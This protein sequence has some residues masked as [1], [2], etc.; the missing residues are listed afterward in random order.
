[1]KGQV[2]SQEEAEGAQQRKRLLPQPPGTWSVRSPL[3]GELKASLQALNSVFKV[4]P[5]LWV[6]A[7]FSTNTCFLIPMPL[8]REASRTCILPCMWA[9]ALA[10]VPPHCLHISE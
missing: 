5:P 2:G 10:L 7:A 8:L 9:P 6:Q 1:M 4:V 3:G